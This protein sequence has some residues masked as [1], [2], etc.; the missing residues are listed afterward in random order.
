MSIPALLAE[1]A[2]LHSKDIITLVAIGGGCVVALFGIVFTSWRRVSQTRQREMSRREVAAYV[3][4]GSMSAQDAAV[5]LSDN[6]T[7]TQRMIANAVGW[8]TIKP[9]KAEALMRA[10]RGPKPG[11]HS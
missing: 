8:G 9:E 3:A 1:E 6:D 4:E 10:A 5:L 2:I 7:E 11:E